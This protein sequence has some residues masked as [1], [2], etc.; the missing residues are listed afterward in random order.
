MGAFEKI[1]VSVPVEM[2]AAL[3]QSVED[4]QYVTES[5]IVRDALNEW[6]RVRE[7]R[8]AKLRWV[9]DALEKADKGPWLSEDEVFRRLEATI[10]RYDQP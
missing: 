3:R 9:R 6:R 8:D 10:A 5:D 7:R 1:T 2:A 4:G